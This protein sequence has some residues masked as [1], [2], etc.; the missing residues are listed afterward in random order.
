MYY[1]YITGNIKPTEEETREADGMGNKSVSIFMDQMS[2]YKKWGEKDWFSVAL[3]KR[4]M[5]KK[6]SK[7]Y[8]DKN[9][10]KILKSYPHGFCG[11]CNGGGECGETHQHG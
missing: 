8:R 11:Q 3:G 2:Y 1:Y 10:Q 5:Q 6:V 7:M 4:M 9:V